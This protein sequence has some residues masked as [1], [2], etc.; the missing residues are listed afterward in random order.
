MFVSGH[1]LA[2]KL[3]VTKFV[4]SSPNSQSEFSSITCSKILRNWLLQEQRWVVCM[5]WEGWYN[6]LQ[7]LDGILHQSIL[8]CLHLTN[9]TFYANF[10]PAITEATKPK[11][12]F[13][14]CQNSISAICLEIS[15]HRLVCLFDCL[16]RLV[17]ME[18]P[19]TDPSSSNAQAWIA[20]TG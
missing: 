18:N 20:S 6:I 13:A 9:C 12:D 14:F 3:N 1:V 8:V 16:P 17:R 2:P 15:Q 10:K 7:W 19:W 11:S 4:L 5:L